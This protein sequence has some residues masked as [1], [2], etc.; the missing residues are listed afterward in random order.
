[1]E[2]RA[3]RASIRIVPNGRSE[4]SDPEAAAR[5]GAAERENLQLARAVAAQAAKLEEKARRIKTLEKLALSVGDAD[6]I[7]ELKRGAAA[8]DGQ[9]LA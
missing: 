7:A 1:M 9:R 3:A 5:A 4:E 6:A 8:H 2:G